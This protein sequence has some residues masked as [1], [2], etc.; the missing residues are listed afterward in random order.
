MERNTAGRRETPAIL[1]LLLLLALILA[2]CGQQQGPP[3]LRPPR[4]QKGVPL[5]KGKLLFVIVLLLCLAG[6]LA[7]C[8]SPYSI[9]EPYDFSSVTEQPEWFSRSTAER[10]SDCNIPEDI[11]HELTT[12][13]LIDT[14]SSHPLRGCYYN[15]NFIPAKVMLEWMERSF[16]AV[17]ELYSREDGIAELEQWIAEMEALSREE[18]REKGYFFTDI[19]VA[20]ALLGEM[21]AR[22]E[23]EGE[24]APDCP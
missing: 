10:L 14:I 20:E 21:Q 23:A 5:M 8:G 18:L 2:A 16:N 3:P 17:P 15:S 24:P 13:A 1:F 19:I 4:P 9:T 7:A 12:R 6:L 11:L 22:A